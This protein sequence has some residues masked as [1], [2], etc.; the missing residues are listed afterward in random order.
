MTTNGFITALCKGNVIS[1]K[2]NIRKHYARAVAD[3]ITLSRGKAVRFYGD[4]R[5]KEYLMRL[6]GL[7]KVNYTISNDNERHLP[8][9]DYILLEKDEVK[10]I[11]YIDFEVVIRR[12]VTDSQRTRFF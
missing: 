5:R 4:M 11:V 3:L 1:S 9:A 8:M 2:L 10:K 6:L 7:I 12:Y